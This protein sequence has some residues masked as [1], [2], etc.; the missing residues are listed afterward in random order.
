MDHVLHQ[1]LVHVFLVNMVE[2]SVNTS[3]V[4][5]SCQTIHLFVEQ[6]DLVLHQINVHVN[7]DIPETIV[8]FQFVMEDLQMIQQMSVLD[9]ELVSLQMFVFHVNMDGQDQDVINQFVLE[10]H[11]MIQQS[12]MVVDS[13]LHKMFVLDAQLDSPDHPVNVQFAMEG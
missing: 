6:K 12:V 11:Q 3:I 4:L 7:L 8:K 1:T 10:K 5:D 2:Y 13:V 9:V